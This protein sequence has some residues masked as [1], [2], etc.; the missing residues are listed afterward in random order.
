MADTS[1]PYVNECGVC[2][3]ALV[4]SA[5]DRW[6]EGLPYVG[7]GSGGQV[8][9]R[10]QPELVREVWPTVQQL[11]IRLEAHARGE[12]AARLERAFRDAEDYARLVD[13][14]CESEAFDYHLWAYGDPVLDTIPTGDAEPEALLAQAEEIG[15]CEL[16]ENL[17]FTAFEREW[18][19]AL[20]QRSAEI[21]IEKYGHPPT[22]NYAERTEMRAWACFWLAAQLHRKGLSHQEA[23]GHLEQYLSSHLVVSET[24]YPVIHEA[25]GRAYGMDIYPIAPMES[26][27]VRGVLEGFWAVVA[28]IRAAVVPVINVPNLPAKQPDRERSLEAAPVNAGAD[29][30]VD[31]RDTSGEPDLSGLELT[32][33][34]PEPDLYDERVVNWFGKRLYLGDENTQVALLF[35]LLLKRLG[36]A[37]PWDEIRNTVFSDTTNSR[38][39]E[40]KQTKQ[41]VRQ[42]VSKLKDRL[43]EHGLND[44]VFI[45]CEDPKGLPSYSM[46]IRTKR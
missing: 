24:K 39:R 12:L 28:E 30:A 31:A 32:G 22:D 29:R 7:S 15:E 6:S 27:E 43:T 20:G 41:H 40:V 10:A 21:E 18:A 33:S 19:A 16:T 36:H 45:L 11:C 34:K 17:Y 38:P 8:T 4:L 37:C 44:H 5:Y 23:R 2:L 14:Y 42:V 13:N 9:A 46:H 26:E 3:F 25:L 35:R 1:N